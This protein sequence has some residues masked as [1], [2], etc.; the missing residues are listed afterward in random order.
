[1]KFINPHEWEADYTFFIYFIA[2][3]LTVSLI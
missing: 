2:D 1:M 3:R